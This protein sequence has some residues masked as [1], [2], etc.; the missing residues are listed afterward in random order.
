MWPALTGRFEDAA[1]R[2]LCALRHLFL[3]LLVAGAAAMASPSSVALRYMHADVDGVV[4][5]ARDEKENE[6]KSELTYPKARENNN[7]WLVE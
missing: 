4:T 7:N 1:A 6:T 3:P 5:W 2:L